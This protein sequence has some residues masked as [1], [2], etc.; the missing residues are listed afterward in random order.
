MVGTIPCIALFIAL[1]IVLFIVLALL[2]LCSG[3]QGSLSPVG[4]VLSDDVLLHVKRKHEKRWNCD[5]GNFS[6]YS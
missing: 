5:A 6:R 3:C 1:F 2:S 4:F